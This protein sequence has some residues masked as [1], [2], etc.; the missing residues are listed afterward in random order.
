MMKI[1]RGTLQ[2]I[3]QEQIVALNREYR[4]CNYEK[5]CVEIIDNT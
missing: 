3:I 2:S 5:S 1:G 4:V